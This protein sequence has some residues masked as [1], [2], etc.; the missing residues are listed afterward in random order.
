[1]PQI[2][3]MD[4]GSLEPGLLEQIDLGLPPD[5]SLTA[6]VLPGRPAGQFRFSLGLTHWGRK[7][8]NGRLY[9]PRTNDK[10]YLQFYG[11]Q[12]NSIELNA[13]H[14]KL[15]GKSGLAKWADSVPTAF[16]FC[17]KL[18]NGITHK[19][20]LSGK[21]AQLSEV[22]EAFLEGFGNKLGSIFIQL[23]EW[24]GPKRSEELKT[25]L[26]SLDRRCSYFLEV[27]EPEWFTSDRLFQMLRDQGI[28]AVI[29]DTA[30][31]R[32]CAHMQL[33]VPR[34]F[35]RFVANDGHPS[36]FARLQD[37]AER[38]QD[39]RNR[40]LQEVNFFVHS[41]DQKKVLDVAQFAVGLFNERCNAGLKPLKLDGSGGLVQ[42]LF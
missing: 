39:W 14:Y 4:F 31:R 30:G 22:Y 16:T 40:G 33:T 17:P 7:D 26:S 15:Y 23:H 21:E 28:G 36:D 18:F 6:L 20:P 41:R 9:P 13:T 35:I 11:R 27:R 38:L 10:D 1:M 12:F 32:D 5:G 24:F 42:T 37:W 29:T 25:F 3:R 34:C 8:W 19:G 2:D